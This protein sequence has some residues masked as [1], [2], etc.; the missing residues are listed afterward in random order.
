L[1]TTGIVF[2]IKRYSIHDGPG[3][4]T[5]VFLKGCPLRCFW[6]HN[7]ESQS[8]EPQFLYRPERCILCEGCADA[9]PSGAVSRDGE[10]MVRDPLQCTLC[11][12][13]VEACPADARE[14][15]GRSLS[16]GE[17]ME[18]IE[19]DRLYFDESGGGV[20]F[21][22]GEPLL[23][24]DFLTGLLQSCRERGVRTAVDTAGHVRAD[25]IAR[26]AMLA[27]LVLLDLKHLDPERHRE[28]TGVSNTLIMS[29]LRRV[30]QS[31]ARVV[32][33]IPM[34]AG[35]NDGEENISETIT[36]LRTLDPVP[37]VNLLPFHRAA[38]DKHRRFGMPYRASENR[39]LSQLEI[40]AICERFLSAGITAKIGG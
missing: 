16:I 31:G 30:V 17:V 27:D 21:S 15:V 32:V 11:G 37:E 26:I 5:T 40:E 10:R 22:G 38:R 6:C 3:I 7:P 1:E 4:R 18:E 39:E 28:A 13:C 36:F 25:I 35:F 33:R 2:D 20:T 8:P 34:V 19:R 9:C 14:L 23:Q 24:P 29:N 12:T